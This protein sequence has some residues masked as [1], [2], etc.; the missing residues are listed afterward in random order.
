MYRNAIH[1]FSLRLMLRMIQRVEAMSKYAIHLPLNHP[2][3]DPAVSNHVMHK[4]AQIFQ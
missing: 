1:G 3:G 2:L 4:A